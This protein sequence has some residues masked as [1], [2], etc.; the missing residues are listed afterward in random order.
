MATKEQLE[1]SLRAAHAAGDTVAANKLAAALR[2]ASSGPS[3]AQQSFDD[4]PMWQK[5]IKAL[6]DLLRVGSDAISLGGVDY[7]RAMAGTQPSVEAAR[8]AT[9]DARERSGS[10]GTA[11]AVASTLPL[12]ALMPQVSVPASAGPVLKGAG[13]LGLAAL[14]GAGW[15]GL[16]ALGHGED[17]TEGQLMGAAFGA[18]GKA[19][20]GVLDKGLTSILDRGSRS[21]RVDP[22]D[23]RLAKNR[24]YNA[25]EDEG[26][27][28]KPSAVDDLLARI[29][30]TTKDAYPGVQGGVIDARSRAKKNLRSGG[31]G[32]QRNRSMV[33][34]DKERQNFRRDAVNHPQTTNKDMGIDAIKTID[35]WLQDAS[36]N[37]AAVTSRSGDPQVALDHLLKGRELNQKVERLDLID[38][39]LGNARRQAERN[40]YT[41]EDSTIK[42]NVGGILANPKLRSM[43]TPDQIEQ[44]EI[45]NSGTAGANLLRQAGRMAWGGGASWPAATA[46]G[47]IG[48]AIGNA[49]GAAIGSAIPGALGILAKKLSSRATKKEAE[50]LVDMV[51]S[52]KS[53]KKIPALGEKGQKELSRFLLSL[54]ITAEDD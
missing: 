11:T 5:P 52:G 18:G 4:L 24:E 27:A 53:F 35:D 37:P 14:E 50:K 10:A 2:A 16:S 1:K 17:V 42:Q 26:V 3:S 6:D 39:R 32:F 21:A 49:P 51:S 41:G 34:I 30:D 38:E 40:L 12:M 44:M 54:G 19:V 7:L 8:Q 23:L 9:D 43:F 45:V 28:F 15:G 47:T 46:G 25:M 36:Q 13:D 20:S 29:D 31:R 22:K 33:E 48:Y